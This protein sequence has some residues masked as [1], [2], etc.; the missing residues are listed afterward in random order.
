MSKKK[1]SACSSGLFCR[2]E[3]F[4]VLHM[5]WPRKPINIVQFSSIYSLDSYRLSWSG[6]SYFHFACTYFAC[7]F[8]HKYKPSVLNTAHPPKVYLKIPYTSSMNTWLETDLISIMSIVLLH[9]AFLQLIQSLI[10]TNNINLI[11]FKS[12]GRQSAFCL[13]VKI[14]K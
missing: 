14:E 6:V 13:E 7:T 9:T 3:A 5:W 11:I 10:F 2:K 1:I 4:A 8:S 12:S